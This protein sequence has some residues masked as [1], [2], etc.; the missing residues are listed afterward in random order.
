MSRWTIFLLIALTA[1]AAAASQAGNRVFF[2]DNGFSIAVLEGSPG[3]ATCQPV[4]MQLPPTGG[5]APNVNVQVQPYTDTL[6]AYVDLS[7]N[8]FESMGL[9]ILN[10]PAPRGDCSVMEYAGSLQGH[11]MHWYATATKHEDHV[12][13]VTAC[14]TEAQWS[15]VSDELKACVDSFRVEE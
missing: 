15:N 1:L 12:Y 8:Q 14:A 5:F 10:D 13:L 2:P 7:L 4:A 9:E 3:A 11:P 6:Q